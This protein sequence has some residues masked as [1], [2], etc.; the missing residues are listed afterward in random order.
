MLGSLDWEES[1]CPIPYLDRF[2]SPS[3][4]SIVLCNFFL[5]FSSFLFFLFLLSFWLSGFFCQFFLFLYFFLKEH[6]L[7]LFSSMILF[8]FCL[9]CTCILWLMVCVFIFIFSIFGIFVILMELIFQGYQVLV[10]SSK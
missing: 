7:I 10:P 1:H 4:F 9:F 3:L 2:V 8:P 5:S 6:C